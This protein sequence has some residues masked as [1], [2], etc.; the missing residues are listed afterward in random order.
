MHENATK[1]VLFDAKFEASE[2]S[3]KL[4]LAG[5]AAPGAKSFFTRDIDFRMKRLASL[6]GYKIEKIGE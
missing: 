6:L 2:L 3:E 4:L 5:Y 1:E